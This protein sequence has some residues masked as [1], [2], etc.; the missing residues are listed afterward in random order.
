MGT[1]RTVL[2]NRIIPSQENHH[3]HPGTAALQKVNTHTRHPYSPIYKKNHHAQNK[4]SQ[5]QTYATDKRET[6]LTVIPLR[7]NLMQNNLLPLLATSFHSNANTPSQSGPECRAPTTST[8]QQSP[9]RTNTSTPHL[10][11]ATHAQ[12]GPT[13]SNI[14]YLIRDPFAPSPNTAH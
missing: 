8:P 5:H 1:L 11:F 12:F 10:S 7:F 14:S 6:P 2:R 4:R 3:K 9:A 13:C